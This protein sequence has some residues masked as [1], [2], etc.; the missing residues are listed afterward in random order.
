MTDVKP[1]VSIIC[2]VF[3]EEACVPLFFQRL[4]AILSPL[5]NSN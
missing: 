2:P 4:Q 3:N 5:W 1:L